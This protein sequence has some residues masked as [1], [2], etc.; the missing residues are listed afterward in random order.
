MEEGSNSASLAATSATAAPVRMRLTGTSSFFPVS[1]RGI[2]GTATTVSGAW[3]GESDVRS[4]PLIRASASASGPR[5]AREVLQ[6][7]RAIAG[8]VWVVPE[9]DRHRG[10][11]LLDDELAQLPDYGCPVRPERGCVDAE[12]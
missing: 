6:M 9:R 7:R 8:A 11:G 3:R 5:P 2:A 12:H 10:H 1:V 4:A